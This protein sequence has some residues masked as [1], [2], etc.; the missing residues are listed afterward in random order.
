MKKLFY[1]SFAAVT[2]LFTSVACENDDEQILSP[3]KTQLE[4]VLEQLGEMENVEDFA[5]ILKDMDDAALGDE[6]L[7]VFAVIDQ[8]DQPA[9]ESE[10][11]AKDGDEGGEG[12]E[13]EVTDENIA[14]HIVKG[15]FD[16]PSE[17]GDE[18]IVESLIGDLLRIERKDGKILVNDV[19]LISAT[20]VEAGLSKIYVVDDVLQDAEITKY[21]ANF[22]VYAAN[23]EWT[24]GAEEKTV[25]EEAKIIFY[26][27]ENEA[28]KKVDSM[29]T[30][31]EGKAA[32]VHYCDSGLYY[33]AEK[34][35]KTSFRENYMVIGLFTTQ[36][37]LDEAPE[38]K[39]GTALDKIALGAL[40]IADMNKD[41]VIDENDKVASGYLPVNNDAENVDLFIVSDTYAAGETEE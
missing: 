13:T 21:I 4:E 41:G 37:Q 6:A 26:E 20:A 3:E 9:T 35:G 16:L 32:Y 12:D 18:I 36:A 1:L 7:T 14:R 19:A 33:S 25:A 30:N 23:E 2:L 38:Y 10:K 15:V 11:T 39:T 34:E 8:P 29:Y 22:T 40:R 27:F 28:Y 31:A 24:E 17:E 5:N